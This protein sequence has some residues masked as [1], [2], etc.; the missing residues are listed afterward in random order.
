MEARTVRLDVDAGIARI[1]LDRPDKLNAFSRTMHAHLRDA[2]DRV[3]SD[4]A[5]RAVLL[6]GAGRAFCAGQDLADLSFEPGNMTD[7]G[8]LIEQNFNPLIRRLRALPKPIVARVSG[9]AAGAGASLALA[10]DIVVAGRS[11]SFL[12]AF[13]NI[14]LVPDS[15]S[16][17]LLPQRVGHARAMALAMLGERL[18]AERA[19]Q[20]GLIWKCVDD[21]AL[22]AEVEGLAARLAAMPTRALAA[23]KRTIG[24]AQ[25]NTLDQ[26]L[27]LE[28]D[29][30]RELGASQDYAEGVNAFLQKRKPVFTGR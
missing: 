29:L 9:I 5:I 18:S 30:Q 10:C 21:E 25:T 17:W 20:W 24:A 19:E 23:I 27:D 2:M 13:V 14:G 6:T 12:Q 11:A 28:R 22:D 16:T 7:L 3:E 4:D 1:T 26:A 8:E 15:G